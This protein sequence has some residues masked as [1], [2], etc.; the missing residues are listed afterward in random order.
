MSKEEME[1]VIMDLTSK[2]YS[3]SKRLNKL[4]DFKTKTEMMEK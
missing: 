2:V 1:K 4:E 3:M